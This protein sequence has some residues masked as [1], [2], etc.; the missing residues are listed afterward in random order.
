MKKI[1]KVLSFVLTIILI[2]TAL[3]VMAQA[4]EDIVIDTLYLTVDTEVWTNYQIGNE[5]SSAAWQLRDCMGVAKEDEEKY[6]IDR[7]NSGLSKVSSGSYQGCAYGTLIDGTTDYKY[8]FNLGCYDGYKFDT[9]PENITVY[10]NGVLVTAEYI[11]YNEYWESYSFAVDINYNPAPQPETIYID[12]FY[13]ELE[14]VNVGGVA[15]SMIEYDYASIFTVSDVSWSCDK[16]AG[17]IAGDIFQASSNYIQT[18]T[19]TPNLGYE[20]LAD[21]ETS[22]YLG[23]CNIYSNTLYDYTYRM[24]GKN[25]VIDVFYQT[26]EVINDIC[27]NIDYANWTNFN[28]G[29]DAYEAEQQF[30]DEIA[31]IPDEYKSKYF[32]DNANTYLKRF[33]GISEYAVQHGDILSNEYE[34]IFIMSIWVEQDVSFDSNPNSMNVYING[35]KKNYVLDYNT[36]WGC[37]T[38]KIPMA[39]FL[40]ADITAD[41]TIVNK[42][43]SVT[44]TA[45][46]TGGSE[47]YKYSYIVYNQATDSW[48]RLADKIASNTYTWT[49]SSEGIRDFYTEVTDA[50]GKTVRSEKYTVEVAGVT[51]LSINGTTSVSFAK[52]GD[53]VTLKGTATG[54]SGSYKYSYI[55]YNKTTDTWARLADNI[56][57]DT[58]KW[59]AGSV[60]DRVFYIDVKDSVGTIVRSN[61]LNVNV[62]EEVSELKISGN[63]NL[64]NT[65]VGQNVVLTGAATGGSGSYKYSYIVYNKD[66]GSWFRLAD[67]IESNTF[68][69]TAG[70]AGNRVFYIDV[71]DGEGTIVRS[72]AIEVVTKDSLSLSISGNAS[73][74]SVE[75]GDT[76]TIT[77]AA[78][79]GTSPY[80]YSILVH[81]VATDSWYRFSDFTETSKISWTASSAGMRKFYVEVKDKTGT[82]VRSS[83][84]DVNVN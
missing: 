61:E 8:D 62:T 63:A 34:Y 33:D 74:S 5:T 24:D 9:N 3:P 69:W 39:P 68:T 76:V 27:L 57:S 4:S 83:A 65:T 40:Q 38:F 82:V 80:T 67:N 13:I 51:E 32:I 1:S 43:D 54:G 70:S 20:F 18:I 31:T 60:G 66:N 73:S 81:N 11:Y 58:F 2:I 12:H 17:F 16:D 15:P 56:E 25:F 26:D 52:V 50:T 29:L 23:G 42:G 77:G 64:S 21:T 72:N 36:Y 19:L 35:V 47:D 71:K 22:E 41:K 45:N 53:V 49:A 75:V 46:G 59:L 79:G 78:T 44:I 84:I 37:Y 10:L 7:G 30:L 28:L 55:V 48:F 6:Y 14:N